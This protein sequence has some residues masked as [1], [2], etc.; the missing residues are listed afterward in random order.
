MN[1]VSL[2]PY[3]LAILCLYSF[4]LLSEEKNNTKYEQQQPEQMKNKKPSRLNK[5]K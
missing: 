5:K 1:L 2:I 3:I 4:D